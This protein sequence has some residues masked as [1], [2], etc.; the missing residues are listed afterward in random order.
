MLYIIIQYIIVLTLCL[1]ICLYIYLVNYLN[2]VRFSIYYYYIVYNFD[3]R[4]YNSMVALETYTVLGIHFEK[5]YI[6]QFIY[7][8][9]LKFAFCMY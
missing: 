7:F 3:S 6:G 9:K 5:L 1:C 8:F 2:G 4:K